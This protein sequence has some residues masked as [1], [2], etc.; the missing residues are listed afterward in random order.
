M[1]ELAHLLDSL[2]GRKDI[3]TVT[4]HREITAAIAAERY[5][6]AGGNCGVAMIPHTL[7]NPA[8]PIIVRD[9]APFTRNDTVHYLEDNK[10][11]TLMLFGRHLIKQPAYSNMKY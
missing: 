9:I 10:I 2:Y 5:A 8:V 6:L 3:K 1:S 11:A 7:G 4:M